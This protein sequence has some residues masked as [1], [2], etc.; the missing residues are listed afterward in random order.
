[1]DFGSSLPSLISILILLQ[2]G[3]FSCRATK[4]AILQ[5]DNI[6]ICKVLRTSGEGGT[7]FLQKIQTFTGSKPL[8]GVTGISQIQN[9]A[10][11]WKYLEC[12]VTYLH[13]TSPLSLF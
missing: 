6:D 5:R 9:D 11:V 8:E 3:C 7:Q 10:F 2:K 4:R 13:Q 12:D 1:M